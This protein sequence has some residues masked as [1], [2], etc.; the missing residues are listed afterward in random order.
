M[1]VLDTAALLYWTLDP[2]RLSSAAA[3][4]ID[5]AD[6]I[7]VSSISIW[8]IA[9]KVRRGGLTLP[10]TVRDYV[11]SLSAVRNVEI[12]PVDELLWLENVELD[13]DHRDPADRTVVALAARSGCPLVTSDR[14]IRARYAAAVW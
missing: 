10:I 3:R 13:W 14:A 8:E 6:R 2:G 9:V 4:T 7:L 11:R 12:V 1:I 5:R